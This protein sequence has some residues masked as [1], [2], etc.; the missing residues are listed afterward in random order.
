[1]KC[2]FTS[3]NKPKTKQM[4]DE[5]NTNLTILKF[6][7]VVS[8]SLLNNVWNSE[9]STRKCSWDMEPLDKNGVFFLLKKKRRWR[10]K[11]KEKLSWF[12]RKQNTSLCYIYRDVC[13]HVSTVF[14]PKK[15]RKYSYTEIYSICLAVIQSFQ[16]GRP[17][18]D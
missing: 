11:I 12:G 15:K 5:I 9:K 8:S 3:H 17:L 2:S 14:M 16:R 7:A 10:R 1:M 18:V 4:R 13:I 6:A